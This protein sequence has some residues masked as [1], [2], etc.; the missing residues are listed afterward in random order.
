M[1]VRAAWYVAALV[2]AGVALPLA[3]AHA[4]DKYISTIVNEVNP[5]N[6]SDFVLTKPGNAFSV[7]PNPK[8]VGSGVVAQ[9]TLKNVSCPAEGNDSGKIGKCGVAIPPAKC[10]GNNVPVGDTCCTGVAMGT[11]APT[12]AVMVLSSHFAGVEALN[13]TGVPI[14]FKG[15]QATFVLTGKNKID[16]SV[17]GALV[18]A[19]LGKPIGFDVTKFQTNGSDVNNLTTGCGVVPLPP[20]GPLNT[21]SDGIPFAFTGITASL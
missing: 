2:A 14:S 21:C 18:A 8:T 11:C 6:T 4:G 15:G 20:A 5:P 12:P 10:K 17:F 3:T 13:V 9:L 16:G 19:I 1:Q 7:A